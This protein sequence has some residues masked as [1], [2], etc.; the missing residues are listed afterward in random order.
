MV[1]QQLTGLCLSS[2]IAHSRRSVHSKQAR[3]GK[4][5]GDAFWVKHAA[6]CKMRCY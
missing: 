4:A 6:F 1:R 3:K 2:P 5:D